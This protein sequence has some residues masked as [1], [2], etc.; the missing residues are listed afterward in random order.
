M[1]SWVAPERTS[2]I[3]NGEVSDERF[4]ALWA[5][6]DNRSGVS[7]PMQVA[8]KLVGIINLNMTGRLR[9]F[10]LGQM[11]ALTILA[12]T[13]AAALESASL[14]TQVRKAEENYR[15][16]FEHAVEGIFQSTPEGRFLTVNPAMARI[17]GYD[18]PEEFIEKIT[19][20]GHQL[21]VDPSDRVAAARLQE[22]AGLLLGYEFEAY[23]IH[24]R[25]I[26][27]ALN[28]LS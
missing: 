15:S 13:A 20:V 25:T 14:Y 26:W 12:G 17:L 18:S 27:L 1:A 16:I 10:T 9:P 28:R 8:N 11:K 6:P 5:R 2:L 7:I 21:Y 22:A 3:R 24:V 19:D 23:R 4:V